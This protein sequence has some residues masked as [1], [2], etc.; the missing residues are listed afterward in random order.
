MSCGVDCILQTLLARLLDLQDT[1]YCDVSSGY[2]DYLHMISTLLEDAHEDTQPISY[3]RTRALGLWRF[4][5]SD[6]TDRST[7]VRI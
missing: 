5:Q 6:M 3:A 7:P 1:L 4:Q 2:F